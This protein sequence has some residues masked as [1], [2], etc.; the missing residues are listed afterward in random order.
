MIFLAFA[1]VSFLAV[2]GLTF[3]QTAH[4]PSQPAAYDER[5]EVRRAAFS[6]FSNLESNSVVDD[7][8]TGIP[9]EWVDAFLL[10]TQIA[11]RSKGLNDVDLVVGDRQLGEKTA[12]EILAG[13]STGTPNMDLFRSTGARWKEGRLFVAETILVTVN[14]NQARVRVEVRSRDNERYLS[15]EDLMMYQV[16]GKWKSF[17]LLPPAIVNVY[18]FPSPEYYSPSR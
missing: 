9:S 16:G 13:K 4:Q 5:D 15:V 8:I 2:S 1:S 12:P 10:Q 11:R 3:F 6:L 17:S 14:G 7:E 18:G